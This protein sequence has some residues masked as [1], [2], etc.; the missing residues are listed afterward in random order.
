MILAILTLI[1]FVLNYYFILPINENLFFIYNFIIFLIL[2]TIAG[3]M[4][5]KNNQNKAFVRYIN[6]FC[7]LSSSCNL[8]ELKQMLKNKIYTLE[9]SLKD[10][11]NKNFILENHINYLLKSLKY[12]K[13]EDNISFVKNLQTQYKNLLSLEDGNI[14]FNNLNVAIINNNELENFLL[15]N[16]LLEFNIHSE[17]F[18]NSQ[19]ISKEYSLIVSKEKIIKDNILC[20]VFTYI[21]AKS[22]LLF[23]QENFSHLCSNKQKEYNVLIF[24]STIFENNLF[25]NIANQYFSH[26]D[27]V[28]YLY[29]FKKSLEKN[30]KLILLDYEVIKYDIQLI[31]NILENYKI[32]N[33][34]TNVL[35]FSK[36]RIK[37]CNFAD[38]ILNDISKKDWILLLKKYINQ[39]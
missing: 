31:S 29:D 10:Q 37:N 25:L 15:Q 14:V 30:Y 27:A 22:I 7:N 23:L 39:V 19:N 36:E 11:E 26:N 9:K 1:L 24:K 28:G 16:I 20:F 35:L 34:H 12:L 3:Y 18:K 13:N 21:D 33:P 17:I 6:N 5:I 32:Q 38:K 8:I 4:I 2:T